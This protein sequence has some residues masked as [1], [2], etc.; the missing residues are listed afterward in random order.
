MIFKDRQEAGRKLLV[1]LFQNKE[2]KKNKRRVLVVSLLRGGIIVGDIIAKGLQ[3]NHLPLV[4]S[5]IPAPESPELAIG[6]LCFDIVYLEKRVVNSIGLDNISI[7]K[8][9]ETAKVKFNSY[10]KRFEIKKSS[11]SRRLKNKIIILVDDGIATGAT[12][13]AAI[14]YLKSKKPKS[15]YLTIPVAPVDFYITGVEKQFILHKDI[16]FGAVSQFYEHFPQVED[17]EVKK[18]LRS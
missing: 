18:L 13:K 8:Q 11:Y 10:L 12:V 7:S 15:I 3:V 1:R 6:A 14:L 5:K 4:V 2:I 16:A 9:I 17:N